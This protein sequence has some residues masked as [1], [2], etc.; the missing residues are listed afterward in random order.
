MIEDAE[1]EEERKKNEE[2][3]HYLKEYEEYVESNGLPYIDYK[4]FWLNNEKLKKS[5]VHKFRVG[6]H[7]VLN[8]IKSSNTKI[9]ISDMLKNIQDEI[10]VEKKLK[11]KRK[12]RKLN[13]SQNELKEHFE[14]SNH[15]SLHQDR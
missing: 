5:G 11:W 8:I 7:R 14:E 12:P 13:P 10:R 3:N 15:I 1:L 2:L 4:M 6:I 9:H